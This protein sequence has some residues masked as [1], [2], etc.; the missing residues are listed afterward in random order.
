LRRSCTQATSPA[1]SAAARSREN[2]A[3]SSAGGVIR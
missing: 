1:S 3:G 2:A